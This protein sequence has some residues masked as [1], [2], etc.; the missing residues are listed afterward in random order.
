MIEPDGVQRVEFIKQEH[1]VYSSYAEVSL[2]GNTNSFV[3]VTSLVYGA[4]FIHSYNLWMGDGESFLYLRTYSRHHDKCFGYGFE[5][6]N[7]V[8]QRATVYLEVSGAHGFLP[9]RLMLKCILG[10]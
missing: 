8:V 7:N 3:S 9:T 4:H 10:C 1:S 5:A 2:S 6:Y